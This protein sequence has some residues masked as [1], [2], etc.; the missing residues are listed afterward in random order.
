MISQHLANCL[1]PSG[2]MPLPEPMFTQICDAILGHDNP[3]K[4]TEM[5]ISPFILFS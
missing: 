3:T 1:V 2:N 4:L 5:Y